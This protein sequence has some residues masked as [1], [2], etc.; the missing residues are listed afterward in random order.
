MRLPI[1]QS[2]PFD[3]SSTL[4]RHF[5]RRFLPTQRSNEA[6][7]LGVVRWSRWSSGAS[8]SPN[9]SQ[10]TGV[11]AHESMDPE[12]ETEVPCGDEDMF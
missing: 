9:R 4:S 10:Y 2:L 11:M 7:G 12:D 8:G 6:P 3:T 1:N 5:V